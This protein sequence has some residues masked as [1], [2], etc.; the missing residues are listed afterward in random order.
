TFESIL[1]AMNMTAADL[2]PPK[3]TGHAPPASTRK[4]GGL[5]TI[6]AYYD[7][8]DEEGKLLYQAVR[9]EPKE[10]RQRRP[11]GKGGWIGNVTGVRKVLFNLPAGPAAHARGETIFIPE[12][13]KDVLNL[14]KI[15]LTATCNAMGAEKWC[16]E[17]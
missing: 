10:F 1:A 7:Y 16:P 6:V 13:E 5:G 3:E 8:V 14:G 2:Y 9:Y 4:K 17:H 15:G 11:D 12:G